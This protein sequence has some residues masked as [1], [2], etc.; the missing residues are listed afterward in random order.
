[1]L[2][3]PF[4]C[5]Y[6]NFVFILIKCLDICRIESEVDGEC[7]STASHPDDCGNGTYLKTCQS[8]SYLHFF[9]TCV[10]RVDCKWKDV[11]VGSCGFDKF[12]LSCLTQE[13]LPLH[14]AKILLFLKD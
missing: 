6:C 4:V 3:N 7:P 8:F 11:F 13:I 5:I 12:H 1:M 10:I 14:Y 2:S 9:F